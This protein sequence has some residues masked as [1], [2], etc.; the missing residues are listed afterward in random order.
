MSSAGEILVKIL[1]N[2]LS[3]C[4]SRFPGSKSSGVI[5]GCRSKRALSSIARFSIE[6]VDRLASMQTERDKNNEMASEEAP[7]VMP[8]EL[9]TMGT[10]K[11]ISDVLDTYRD[12]VSRWWPAI[13]IEQ[14]E[15]DHKKLVAEYNAIDSVVKTKIDQNDHRR[16]FILLGMI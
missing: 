10:A 11:F 14:I 1:I 5:A 15:K 13:E 6:L 7:P 3:H 16:R 9:V 2:Q 4:R 8:A 12:H